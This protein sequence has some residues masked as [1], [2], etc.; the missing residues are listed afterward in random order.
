MKVPASGRLA[1]FP[2]GDLLS[3][4]LVAAE[5]RVSAREGFIAALGMA[6]FICFV[7]KEVR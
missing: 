4:L 7:C 6:S 3:V 2:G 5:A 1:P